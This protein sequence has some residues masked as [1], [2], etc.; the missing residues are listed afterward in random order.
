MSPEPNSFIKHTRQEIQA[1]GAFLPAVSPQ[2]AS[3]RREIFRAA[4]RV[5]GVGVGEA[6]PPA[7]RPLFRF[8]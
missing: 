1:P 8:S 3:I 4:L 7:C 2:A 6:H 5:G